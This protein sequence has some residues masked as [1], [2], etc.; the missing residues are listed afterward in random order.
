[1]TRRLEMRRSKSILA[2]ATAVALA[3]GLFM[4]AEAR[5]G[6][7]V[8]RYL[9]P[10]LMER[11]GANRPIATPDG[12]ARPA[13]G[14]SGIECVTPPS[15]AANVTLDCPDEYA[16]STDEPAI[17]VDPADP[18]HVVTAALNGRPPYQT[19]QTAASFDGGRSWT[20]GDLPERPDTQNWDPWL[21]FDVE[22]HTV[23]LALE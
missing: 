1:M 10:G 12:R 2:A 18:D 8:S 5:A 20:I 14:R 16:L 11:I 4:P 7:T 3:L 23:V 9:P 19:I 22:R 15:S 6:A 17:A 13:P 21:S